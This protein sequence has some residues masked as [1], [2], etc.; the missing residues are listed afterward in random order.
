ML[1]SVIRNKIRNTEPY[2][3]IKH[4][5]MATNVFNAVMCLLCD[6]CWYRVGWFLR[7][8]CLFTVTISLFNLQA[9]GPVFFRDAFTIFDDLK[10]EKWSNK[11]ICNRV[12]F[13]M[14]VD[15]NEEHLTNCSPKICFQT[16]FQLACNFKDFFNLGDFSSLGNT[17]FL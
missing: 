3:T 13:I 14:A 17:F 2:T 11:S 12:W 16:T 9:L 10:L 7:S 8:V 4:S 1:L 5:V 6:I 15:S